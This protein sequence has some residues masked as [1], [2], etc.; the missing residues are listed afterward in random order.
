MCIFNENGLV[1]D[2]YIPKKVINFFI[3]HILNP[4]LR[5][6]NTDFTLNSCLFGPVKLTKNANPQSWTEYLEQNREIH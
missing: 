4:C 1:N 6:L 2:I 5:D 3:S